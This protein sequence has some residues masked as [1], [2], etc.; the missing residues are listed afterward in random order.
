MGKV[1]P[2]SWFKFFFFQGVW[3]YQ[4]VLWVMMFG[5]GED[6]LWWGW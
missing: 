6:S 5:F 4:M 1:F 2:C 3:N